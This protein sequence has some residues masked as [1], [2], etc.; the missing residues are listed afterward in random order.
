MYAML[1]IENHS[2][3]N[4]SEINY[5][6]KWFKAHNLALIGKHILTCLFLSKMILP[7]KHDPQRTSR[8]HN[9]GILK[10]DEKWTIN[11]GFLLGFPEK[12]PI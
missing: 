5:I 4:E 2:F 7:M 8:L 11:D 3:E 1:T 9:G 12:S 6:V 10:T